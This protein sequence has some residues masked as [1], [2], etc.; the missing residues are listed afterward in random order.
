M[1]LLVG[2]AVILL[3]GQAA[4]Q[5][6]A[7]FD[8]AG[9]NLYYDHQHPC[10]WSSA[11]THETPPAA[12]AVSEVVVAG[13]AYRR[14]SVTVNGGL[15]H[16]GTGYQDGID[17]LV[18]AFNSAEAIDA[19]YQNTPRAWAESIGRVVA[20]L[21]P[22]VH[23]LLPQPFAIVNFSTGGYFPRFCTHDLGHTGVR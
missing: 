8:C 11:I 16:L 23:Y 5:S 9:V 22:F 3:S 13:N 20:Q 15:I 18:P 10:S 2:A 7:A 19:S 21:P 14:Y 6:T 12:H 1:K 17:T 4:A